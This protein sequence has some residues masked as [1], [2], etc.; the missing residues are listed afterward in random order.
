MNQ[1]LWVIYGRA[2]MSVVRVSRRSIVRAD[3]TARVI[4]FSVF[5]FASF[6]F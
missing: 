4:G 3:R 5:V 1:S 2:D 6:S